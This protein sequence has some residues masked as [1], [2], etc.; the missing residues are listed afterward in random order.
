MVLLCSRRAHVL[1]DC[2]PAPIVVGAIPATLHASGLAA[3]S[4]Q[5]LRGLARTP[6]ITLVIVL[7]LGLG[8]GLNTAIF[9][10]VH[11]VLFDPL[12]FERADELMFVKGARRGAAASVFGMSYPDYRDFKVNQTAFRDLA[13]C[14]YWTFT[15]T[16]TDVPLRL[17]GQ[18][19]SGSFFPLLGMRPVAGRWID[20]N[21][22]VPGGP[23]VVVLSHGLWQRVFAGDPAVVGRDLNING[24][25]AQI[26]GVMPAA[27]R[28]PF[29]DVE[30]WVPA[31]NELDT[32]PRGSRFLTTV[33]RLRSGVR[34]D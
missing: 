20:A 2:A 23:E 31:R 18:R 10:V 21:D 11:S 22:D 32:I 4:R 27:F 6:V 8:F 24:L 15:V 28:F 1:S 14:T 26:V 16:G 13:V 12:P 7:T 17:V 9:S 25:R 29:D 30:L 3:E 5:S 34:H 19:V 33:G